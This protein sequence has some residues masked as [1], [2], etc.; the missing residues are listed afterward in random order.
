MNSFRIIALSSSGLART[1][2]K[3]AASISDSSYMPASFTPSRN[4][5]GDISSS[6]VPSGN[7]SGTEYF[8][9]TDLAVRFLSSSISATR[10]KQC[11]A[12]SSISSSSMNL[13]IS[14]PSSRGSPPSRIFGEFTSRFSVAL[15]YWGLPSI[16]FDFFFLFF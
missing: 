13:L 3:Q 10:M 14:L 2:S 8:V 12:M 5:I 15:G 6:M 16:D 1:L 11:S 7:C 9:K 4:A